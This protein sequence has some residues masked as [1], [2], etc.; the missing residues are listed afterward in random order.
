M[1]QPLSSV[2]REFDLTPFPDL[3]LHDAI[4]RFV[5]DI[6]GPLSFIHS[7]SD[8][9]MYVRGSALRLPALFARP[10]ESEM[11]NL[12][13]AVQISLPVASADPAL[14]LSLALARENALRTLAEITPHAGVDMRVVILLLCTTLAG[15]AR[16]AERTAYAYARQRWS[17]GRPI[18]QYQ[19]VA[20]RLAEAEIAADDTELS[21]LEM[22][23]TIDDASS[24]A[25]NTART[26]IHLADPHFVSLA[27]HIMVATD[28]A[29]DECFMILAGYGYT[30]DSAPARLRML[31]DPIVETVRRLL[32]AHLLPIPQLNQSME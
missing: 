14:F 20:R 9:P 17:G 31:T 30:I 13:E 6:G 29:V 18:W 5:R 16:A 12:A 19:A 27:K 10:G 32:E 4:N 23:S 7:G 15:A 24:Q 21:I 22:A 11:P 25:C 8:T 1:P 2:G 28:T 26:R 3:A